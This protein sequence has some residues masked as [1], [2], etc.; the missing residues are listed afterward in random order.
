MEQNLR[1][2]TIFTRDLQLVQPGVQIPST[3]VGNNKRVQIQR[4][5]FR[6]K[7]GLRVGNGCI[8]KFVLECRLDKLVS[9]LIVKLYYSRLQKGWHCLLV[10]K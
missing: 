1:P 4:H 3:W 10:N 9:L 5:F 8:L 2:P 7:Y 6:L